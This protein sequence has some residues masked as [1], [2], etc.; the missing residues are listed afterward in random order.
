MKPVWSHRD[1][2]DGI[3]AG[4][5][6]SAVWFNPQHINLIVLPRSET[7]IF[8]DGSENNFVCRVLETLISTRRSMRSR[9]LGTIS[10]T[11]LLVFFV[12]VG[13]AGEFDSVSFDEVRKLIQVRMRDESVPLVVVGVVHGN[14]QLWAEGFGWANREE[15]I[16]ATIHTP[17][18]VGS[19]TKPLTATTLM[20]LVEQGDLELERH[21]NE[22]LG[23]AK[24][25]ARLPKLSK[26]TLGTVLQHSS[27][28]PGH[29]ETY[30]ADETDRPHPIELLIRRYGKLM[31]RPGRWLGPQSE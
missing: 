15:R 23:Q 3:E 28:L 30:F 21:I 14:K 4:S 1:R 18:R 16:P 11:L 10:A 5:L 9:H 6:W 25:E 7:A 17:Y 24:V 2:Q 29:W 8:A 19:T 12:T 27:G 13:R 26:A 31:I 20:M 22:Y